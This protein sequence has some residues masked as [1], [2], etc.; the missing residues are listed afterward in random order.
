MQF[1]SLSPNL[2]SQLENASLEE[3]IDIYIE[4][5]LWY[6][7]TEILIEN[8]ENE[9]LWSQVLSA[10]NLS[11]LQSIQTENIAGEILPIPAE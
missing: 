9:Q 7:L 6:N 2:E 1:I 4:N 11:N 5:K 10:M 8:Q 3:K